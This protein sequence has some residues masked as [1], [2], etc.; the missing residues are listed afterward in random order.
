[1]NTKTNYM[2]YM[3]NIP[4]ESYLYIQKTQLNWISW[5]YVLVWEEVF[6]SQKQSFCFINALLSKCFAVVHPIHCE[7]N[8][9]NS[10]WHL[11]YMEIKRLHKLLTEQELCYYSNNLLMQWKI[12]Q[13]NVISV[14]KISTNSDEWLWR[15]RKMELIPELIIVHY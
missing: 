2:T 5:I 10:K 3:V 11:Q 6:S 8:N 9:G 15:K 1:M 12:W 13:E 4:S 7:V 14:I